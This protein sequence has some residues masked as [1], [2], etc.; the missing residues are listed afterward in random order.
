MPD[1]LPKFV[2]L[3]NDAERTG[4]YSMVKPALETMRALGPV[5]EDHLHVLLPALVRLIGPSS[6]ATPLPIQEETLATMQDLLPRMQLAGHSSAVLHPLVRLLD[7]PSDELR[8]RALD[9]ICSVALAIG[10]DFAIFVPTVKKVG[11]GAF[12]CMRLSLSLKYQA[13]DEILPTT[14]DHDEAPHVPACLIHARRCKA[15]APR[16]ALHVGGRRLGEQQWIPS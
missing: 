1:L 15:A 4:D 6:S 8:E 12:S 11:F 9:T 3:F 13:A 10:P 2:A 7:A 16:A 14:A 5:L